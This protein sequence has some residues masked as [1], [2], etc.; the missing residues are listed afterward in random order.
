MFIAAGLF[1]ACKWNSARGSGFAACTA[2]VTP[3][4]SRCPTLVDATHHLVRPFDP[5]R[6]RILTVRSH[7][8]TYYYVLLQLEGSGVRLS[9]FSERELAICYR[10]SVCRL[11]VVC[12]VRAPYLGGSSFRQYFY[13]IRYLGHP[14]TT[15]EFFTEIIPGEPLRRGS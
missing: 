14:L 7:C 4:C 6:N 13:G 3:A 9:I 12:N 10:P 8:P 1:A 11:S 15:T 5:H 2:A